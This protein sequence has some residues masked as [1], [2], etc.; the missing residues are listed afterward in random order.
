MLG[1]VFCG[2]VLEVP[3]LAAMIATVMIVGRKLR[4][5]LVKSGR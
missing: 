1:C 2:G 4:K 3:V 5:W